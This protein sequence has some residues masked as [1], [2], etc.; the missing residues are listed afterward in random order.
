MNTA[1][2]RL[3]D[4]TLGGL[5]AALLGLFVQKKSAS[6][7]R[8]IVVIQL[9]GIGETVL[10]LPAISALKEK[11]SEGRLDVLVTERNKDVYTKIKGID[12]VVVLGMNP[13][14]ILK[15]VL[16]YRNEYDLVI[17]LEEYLNV[18]ALISFFIGRFRVGYDHGARSK[19]YHQKVRYNAKQ[20][21]VQTFV[22]AVKSLG[23]RADVKRLHKLHYSSKDRKFVDSLLKRQG[24]Q[25]GEK[26]VGIAPGAAESAKCRMWPSERFAEL[27]NYLLDNGKAKVIFTGTKAEKELIQSIT[28]H[29]EK[30]EKVIDLS[31]KL[32]LPQLFYFLERC[33]VFLGNDSGPMHIAAAQKTK[34]V[35][36]FGPNLPT[37]FG[38]FG[39]GNVSIYKGNICEFS[40]CINVHLGEVP[41]CLYPK[42]SKDYQKCM[43]NISVS[44]VVEEVE[45]AL[46]KA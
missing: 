28:T 16:K 7:P 18:S 14:H 30:K 19:I 34:V 29:I 1:V 12:R 40:P 43:K 15:F 2:I 26:I 21:C 38:P 23:V 6:R 24:I 8:R 3:I 33:S 17:D 37:R 31:G 39:A 42:R 5:L 46:K 11:F 9:W 44:V 25:K 22:D 36:L 20:H 32:T 45:R 13:F 35:G 10:T 41:D 27:S 4:K